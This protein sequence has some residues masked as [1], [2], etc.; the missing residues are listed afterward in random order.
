[1]KPDFLIDLIEDTRN[2]TLKLRHYITKDEAAAAVSGT[3]ALVNATKRRAEAEQ[4][5]DAQSVRNA[6]FLQ[7]Q[8]E[9][10]VAIFSFQEIC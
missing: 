10:A 3:R 4:E 2:A 5:E 8:F 1:M 7:G 9:A 6:D